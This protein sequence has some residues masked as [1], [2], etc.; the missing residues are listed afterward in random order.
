[1]PSPSRTTVAAPWGLAFLLFAANVLSFVDRMVLTLLVQPIQADLGIGDTAISLLHGLA[2][3]VFY[4]L[5]GLPLGWL[6]DRGDRPRLMAGGVALWSGMTAACGLAVSYG[7]MFVARMGVAVGE[8]VLSPAAVSILSER[9]PKALLA[10][11]I[12]VFQSGIFVGSALALLAGGWLLGALE[13]LDAE[14]LPLSPWRIVFLAIGV[15]GLLVAVALLFVAEPR[16]TA[17]AQAGPGQDRGSLTEAFAWI[18]RRP[19]LYGGHFAAFTAIT[20]MAYG[21][22]SWT[23]TA[24]VRGFGL[25]PAEAGLHLGLILLIA[26]PAGV[27]G[28]GWL[29]DRL[30]ASG[31]KDGPIV[32]ALWGV[33]LFTLALPAY[34]L[35]PSLGL[36]LAAAAVLAFAQ[37]YPY[38][39]ASASLALVTPV[40]LRGQVTA[41]YLMISNLVGL[42]LGPLIVALLTEQVFGRPEALRYSLALLPLFAAP[43][44]FLALWF[45]RRAYAAGVEETQ[46]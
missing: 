2:F 13:G 17:R 20:V 10:R 30:L 18:A 14:T 39:I 37:S 43:V 29:I 9:F 36:A 42:T 12:G 45:S 31:R 8:A 35:A 5:L 25:S 15:P 40:R 38:G 6:A 34:A 3:A 26:G 4:A 19:R 7:W 24:L 44:A 21:A 11:A 33:G 1:M 16:R 23:P 32:A 46:Q 41:I 22:L 28:S 27:Y